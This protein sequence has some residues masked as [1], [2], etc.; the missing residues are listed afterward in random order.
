MNMTA[1]SAYAP[2][3]RQSSHLSATSGNN[4]RALRRSSSVVANSATAGLFWVILRFWNRDPGNSR[5]VLDTLAEFVSWNLTIRPSDS[6]DDFTIDDAP[7]RR[8]GLAAVLQWLVIVVGGDESRLGRTICRLVRFTR[9]VLLRSIWATN[10]I[11][12]GAPENFVSVENK[13]EMFEDR[14]DAQ[15]PLLDGSIV[16]VLLDGMSQV[17]IIKQDRSQIDQVLNY[18]FG[19]FSPDGLQKSLWMIASSSH[20]LLRRVDADISDKF[21]ML[22]FELYSGSTEDDNSDVESVNTNILDKGKLVRWTEDADLYGWQGK[23]AAIILL[24]QMS[25]HIHRHDKSHETENL[26]V[27]PIIQQFPEQ[28]LL[29]GL[30][31]KVSTSLYEHHNRELSTGMIPIPMRIFGIMPLRH[32][33]TLKDLRVVQS[34]VESASSLNEEMD[35]MIRRFRKATNRRLAALQDDARRKGKRV[36]LNGGPGS[37]S[38]LALEKTDDTA[39]KTNPDFHDDQILE[40]FPFDADMTPAQDHVVTKTIRNFI[41]D[42]NILHTS[43]DRKN[44]AFIKNSKSCNVVHGHVPAAIVSLSGGVDSMVI[45]SALAYIRDTEAKQRNL[46]PED[47]LQIYA[48]HIDYANRPESGAEAAYVERYSKVIGAKF[49]CRRIDEVTRGVTARDDYERIAREIRFGLYR[50]CSIE[51]KGCGEGEGVGIMLGHHRGDL[52]ENVISNAHRGCG[53]LDLSGMTAVSKNDGVTLFRPLLPLEKTAVYD[54][55]HTFG[56]PYFKDTTPHWSTRGKLRNRLLPLLEEIYGEGSMDNLSSLA[57]ESD[58]ARTLLQQT[59]IRPF[60]EQV[61][62]PPMGIIFGTASWKDCG[63]FFWK[64]VLREVL[65]SAG[66][67]MFSDKSVESFLKRI[68]ATPLREGWLQCRKDYGVFLKKDGKVLVFHPSS[69]PFHKNDQYEK[70]S[71][72]VDFGEANKV[73][74]GPWTVSCEII[75]HSADAT[76]L[77]LLKKKAIDNLEQLMAGN[78]QYFISAPIEGEGESPLPLSIVP[79]F[80]KTTRPMAWKGSDSKVESTLP[81]LGVDVSRVCT[82]IESDAEGF[83]KSWV[84]VKVN[85]SLDEE[86]NS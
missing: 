34:D 24:D 20:E 83:G 80:T 81:L 41:R 47:V 17:D 45:A 57:E 43:A 6:C 52:R 75:P 3:R 23:V 30:A 19:Q 26:V 39:T 21:R 76:S 46:K 11:F 44:D 85:L 70:N 37:G 49:F 10:I 84:L 9:E 66:R 54:Y 50:E 35:R 64:V 31:Y 33:S 2:P 79:G 77:H 63:L 69:F 74:V 58:D 5:G 4:P 14:I 42:R 12:N 82:D 36:L 1:T 13:R 25:R 27:S 48:I 55:A 15:V 62:Y 28:K 59:I 18:W 16:P 65:H 8:R 7:R 32:A 61:K 67:G 40:C 51:A 68:R 86:V 29:D 60:M 73:K 78:V 72:H 71:I 22:I 53:P 56:V 38:G